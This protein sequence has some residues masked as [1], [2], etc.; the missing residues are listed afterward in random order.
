MS[1]VN[2]VCEDGCDVI[3]AAL[4]F[5]ECDPDWNR[6]QIDKIYMASLGADDLVNWEA[7]GEWAT[8][9]DNTDVADIDKIRYF[10]VIGDK[11]V[12]EGEPKEMSLARKAIT[13]KTH[14]IN[15]SID[16]TNE[17]NYDFL[18]Q[19]E[20]GGNVK[21][22]FASGKYLYGGNHGIE[23]FVSL[24]DSIPRDRKEYE[25]FEGVA[26]WESQFHPERCLNPIV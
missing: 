25:T 10:H 6:A 7:P 24:N 4:S 17:T 18:R 15:F 11:P 19:L 23:A 20:C 21:I 8:R 5:S 26:T 14:T 2:P 3:L 16:E 13:D 12:A 9:I 22:W 1:I